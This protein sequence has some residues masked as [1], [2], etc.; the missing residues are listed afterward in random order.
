MFPFSV[1]MKPAA[2]VTAL[3]LLVGISAI[4]HAQESTGA[5]TYYILKLIRTGP[6]VGK[7]HEMFGQH[8]LAHPVSLSEVFPRSHPH[9]R[10]DK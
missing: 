9:T 10:E 7:W 6:A 3:V 2:M 5:A 4:A 1:K 8:G